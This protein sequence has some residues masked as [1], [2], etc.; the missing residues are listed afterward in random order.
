MQCCNCSALHRRHHHHHHHSQR[1]HHH[2]RA[3]ASL[4]ECARTG[5]CVGANAIV[6]ECFIRGS[7]TRRAHSLRMRRVVCVCILAWRG[8]HVQPLRRECASRSVQHQLGRCT[9]T[10]RRIKYVNVWWFWLN[11]TANI[12]L[13]YRPGDMRA[14]FCTDHPLRLFPSFFFR[15]FSFSLS[16]SR[17]CCRPVHLQKSQAGCEG[18][19]GAPVIARRNPELEIARL[20]GFWNSFYRWFFK[21]E[22][23]QVRTE[24]PEMFFDFCLISPFVLLLLVQMGMSVRGW[25]LRLRLIVCMRNKR[26]ILY[27]SFHAQWIKSRLYKVSQ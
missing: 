26:R 3:S 23:G 22:L 9:C 25:N 11:S 17:R 12:P 4:A 27:L 14:Y 13:A 7:M 8:L 5:V 6:C 15:S 16:L 21:E 1:H 10:P 2:H 18:R 20:L 19:N 24:V